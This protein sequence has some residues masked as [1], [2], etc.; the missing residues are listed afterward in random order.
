MKKI[1]TK[2]KKTSLGIFALVLFTGSVQATTYT[3]T[4]SG[5]WSSALTWGGAG[6]PGNTV[7]TIDNV[8]IPLGVTVT[9]DMDVAV[10]SLASYISVAGSLTSTTNSLTITQGSLQG[11]GVMNLLYVEIG[12]LG[13]MTFSGTITTNRFVN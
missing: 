2:F 1:F 6:S 10:N 13:S 11:T 8:V 7:G 4:Q 3:A 9:M 5:N 12:A